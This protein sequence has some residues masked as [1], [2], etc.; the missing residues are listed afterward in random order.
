[1]DKKTLF[2]EEY[3]HLVPLLLCKKTR[4][5]VHSIFTNGFNIIMGDSLVFIGNRKN[6]L[7]PFGIHL[8]EMDT[9]RAVAAVNNGD[10]VFWNIKT[11]SLEF[12]RITIR[13][14]KGKSFKNELAELKETK[15]FE[16]SFERL[17]TQLV[18]IE[19]R[20]GLDVDIQLFLEK[21][22]ERSGQTWTD[23]ETFIIMLIEAATSSDEHSIEKA[24]RYFLGR[25]QGLTPSG[26]DMVVGLL[27]FDAV[28]HFIFAP[29]YQKLSKLLGEPITTDVGREYLRYALE[30]EFSSTVSKMVNALVIERDSDFKEVF[31]N[32]LGVGHSSGMD[33]L[34]GILIG[35]LAYKNFYRE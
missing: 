27:A 22:N 29:F 17:F 34:F 23:T 31:G 10:S 12:P 28:S 8:R 26:D 3:S 19:E 24:L 30:H 16:A 9:S 2:G 14:N 13:L 5:Q 35:M 6:G 4:G 20:T 18:G 11:E 21:W 1:M 15:I 33:T 7:L 32:L 25:G